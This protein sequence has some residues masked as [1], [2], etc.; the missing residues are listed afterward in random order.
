MTGL[1][2]SENRKENYWEIE[3]V[4]QCAK[5]LSIDHLYPETSQEAEF[6]EHRTINVI[7]ED[8]QQSTIQNMAWLSP[9]V[10]TRLILRIKRV[11]KM[12]NRKSW[13]TFSSFRKLCLKLSLR[14][15]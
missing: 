1:E 3:F 6:K 14:K 5:N 15:S 12:Q 4:L 10:L 2:N 7:Q 9:S 8:L 11:K 13:K